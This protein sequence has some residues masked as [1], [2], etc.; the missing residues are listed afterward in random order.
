MLRR[1]SGL[2]CALVCS[3]V[4]PLACGPGTTN[5]ACDDGSAVAG[6][7]CE[8]DGLVCDPGADVCVEHV[9]LEC[10]AGSWQE[11]VVAA[12]DCG[13]GTPTT[14][15][16][17]GAP[18]TGA[19]TGASTDS[20]T[21]PSA[22]TTASTGVDTVPC[23]PQN[24]PPEGAACENEGEFCSSGCESPCEFCNI[25]T[26]ERGVWQG[27]EAPPANCLDC[28]T[29]CT[30]VVPAGCENGPLAQADCVTGC[31][32]TEAGECRV[33]FH[34]TLACAGG[35]PTFSCDAMG[36]PVVAGCEQQFDDLYMCS[37][38]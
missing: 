14:G 31:Q 1:L 28:E 13:T 10:K 26:C 30:F 37:G 38:L 35:D 27:L 36:R 25:V 24:I 19:S 3:L 32:A 18:T 4:L 33:P 34:I 16:S 6:A 20:S 29:L 9:A 2:A 15:A 21:D 8:Q 7:A 5:T 11:Q 17:T 12:I 23:D 22:G